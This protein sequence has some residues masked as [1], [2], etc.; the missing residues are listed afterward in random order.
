MKTIA[1]LVLNYN[2][3]HFLEKCFSSLMKQSYKKMDVFL[4]D[5]N[6]ID[7]S[8]A[9]TKK[10]YPKVKIIQTGGNL[11]YT[12]AYNF[13][14]KYFE[15]KNVHYDVY[16]LL[17][18][19]TESPSHMVEE[20]MNIFE[21]NPKVGIVNPAVVNDKMVLDCLGGTFLFLTG[22]TQGNKHNQKY[23]K[24]NS[25]Y[26][27]F[28]ASGCALFVTARL[29]HSLGYFDDYFIYY[30]D[31]DLSWKVNNAGYDVVAT[32]R[33]YVKHL[34]GGS[35]TASTF[36]LFL[37][38]KNRILTYWQNLSNVIFIPLIIPFIIFRL[39]LLFYLTHNWATVKAKLT[40]IAK[41]LSLLPKFKKRKSSIFIQLK[42][43]VEMN[44]VMKYSD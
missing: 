4:I 31:V 16:S 40:G 3:K 43:I 10:N 8:V 22:T 29:F 12:G 5:N 32:D 2:G 41:G 39:C 33:T 1:I 23:K 11:G 6:S 36:Q 18:N 37:I 9:F 44:K 7:G 20:V 21:S 38:E 24:G 27:S 30:E 34:Q 28:W 26:K 25:I 13:A 15:K 14:A 35:K 17:N 42:T 19:D